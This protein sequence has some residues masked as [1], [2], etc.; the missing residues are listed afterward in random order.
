ME[1][2]KDNELTALIN[3]LEDPDDEIFSTIRE[4]I[5]S[6]GADVIPALENVWENTF[7]NV[8]QSR[9]EDIIQTIQFQILTKSI[10]ESKSNS[11]EEMFGLS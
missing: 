9:I 1:N 3:L 11:L 5:L 8:L 10:F 7:N 4:K 2:I 6:M